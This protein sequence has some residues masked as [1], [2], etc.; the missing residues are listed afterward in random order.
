MDWLVRDWHF[1]GFNGQM[2]MLLIAA[3]MALYI[4][5]LLFVRQRT[6]HY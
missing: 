6:G 3:G 5:V 4:A 1:L 2:W